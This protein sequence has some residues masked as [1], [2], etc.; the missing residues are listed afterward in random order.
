MHVSALSKDTR[1]YEHIDPS[2][3]GTRRTILVSDMAGRASVTEKLKELGI[4]ES[5][6]SKQ[7]VDRVKSLES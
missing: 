4:E 1:T 3:V 2:S 7:I 6:D 5:D